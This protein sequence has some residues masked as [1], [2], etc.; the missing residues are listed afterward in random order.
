MRVTEINN[1]KEQLRSPQ[2]NA[3]N[4]YI[5]TSSQTNQ[6]INGKVFFGKRHV[7][8]DNENQLITLVKNNTKINQTVENFQARF[9]TLIL[10]VDYVV[11]KFKLF[12]FS[13]YIVAMSFSEIHLQKCFCFSSEHLTPMNE[14]QP[15]CRPYTLFGSSPAVLLNTLCTH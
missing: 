15:M 4:Q 3:K 5:I 9:G 2:P 1:N 6:T 7:C 12:P 11:H 14:W 10:T 13:R 8:F